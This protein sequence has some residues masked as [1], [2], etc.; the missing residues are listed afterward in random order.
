M[1]KSIFVIL[2]STILVNNYVFA[3]FLGVC[4]FLGVS[5]KVD[6]AIGMG[7]AVTFVVVLASALTWM[8]QIFILNPLNIAYLQTIAFILVIASLV[9]FVEMFIKKASPAL[10]TAMGVYLPLITTNCVVLGVAVLNIQ[11]EYNLIETIF[12][13]FGASV[14]FTLALLFMSCLREKLAIGNV[15]KAL[16]GVPIALVSAGLMALAFSGFGG[17]V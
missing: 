10:Y 9:Q 5:A 17:L 16:Q 6:T 4:P 13:G 1:L 11:K 14:G 2:V 8:I 7:I 15:P 12:S 3:Q